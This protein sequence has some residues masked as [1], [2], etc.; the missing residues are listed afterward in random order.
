MTQ[1]VGGRARRALVAAGLVATLFAPRFACAEDVQP[2][3]SP[4]LIDDV[5]STKQDPYPAFDNFAWRAFVALAWPA[6]TGPSPSRRAR[7][8][9]DARRPRSPRLGDLQVALRSLSARAGRPDAA[10]RR[11]GPATTASNPCGADA[12][13]RAKTLAVVRALRRLQS[14]ELHAGQVPRPAGGAEPRL[15]ALRSADQRGRVRLDR[16][17]PLVRARSRAVARGAGA[18]RCRV[19]RGEGGLAH[20]RRSRHARRPQ[21]LLRRRGRAGGR[22]R[23]EPRRRKACLRRARRRVGRTAYRGQDE[24]PAAAAVEHVR[25]CRQCAARRRR[26]RARTGCERR[27]RALFVQRPRQGADRRRAAAG[28]ALGPTGR[29]RPTRRRSIRSRRRSCAGARSIPR[30][31]R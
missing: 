19:D 9:E 29:T 10:R 24:I 26:R 18:F 22:R 12:D 13:N 15:C 7:P 5:P 6:L 8:R 27:G 25:A 4:E 20:S 1:G 17:A 21:P 16:R 11:N 14:G 23:Q 31:W 3:V 28:L 2:K 30:P